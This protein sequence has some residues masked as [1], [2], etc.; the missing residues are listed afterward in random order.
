[1]GMD[2]Y[3]RFL[4]TREVLDEPFAV[5]AGDMTVINHTINYRF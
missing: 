1:M 2:R 4:L 5:A 3:K